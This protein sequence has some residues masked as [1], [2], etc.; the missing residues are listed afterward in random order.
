MHRNLLTDCPQTNTH[1]LV[2]MADERKVIIE[3]QTAQ[4]GRQL[5]S[6]YQGDGRLRRVSTSDATEAEGLEDEI[7]GMMS[8]TRWAARDVANLASNTGKSV[9]D[10]YFALTENYKVQQLAQ[11]VKGV[12]GNV[13]SGI[14]SVWSGATMGGA[15][16]GPVGAVAGAVIGAT[17]WAGSQAVSAVMKQFNQNMDIATR[18]YTMEYNRTLA[19]LIVGESRNTES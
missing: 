17:V 8:I 14:T 2:N 19:G 1:S 12:I 10:T 9:I 11:N 4:S 5:F 3:L 18:G 6:G 15:V 16:G 7:G 13:T